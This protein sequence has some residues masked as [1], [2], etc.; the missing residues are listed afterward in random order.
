MKQT[1]PIMVGDLLKAMIESDG[2]RD[3]FDRQK[4]AYLWSEVV[5]Q[6]IN[7]ATLNRHVDGNTMHVYLNSAAIKSEL[8]YMVPSII[9]SLNAAIGRHIIKKIVIH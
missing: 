3:A 7:R 2:D 9:E 6:T 5:G 4:A 8:T 1:E